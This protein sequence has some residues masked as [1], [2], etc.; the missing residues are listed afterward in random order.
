MS[1]VIPDLYTVYLES[2]LESR[3]VIGELIRSGNLVIFSKYGRCKYI[4]KKSIIFSI[5]E[6]HSSER[7]VNVKPA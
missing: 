5:R 6:K 4:K 1:P 2:V 7:N 3:G